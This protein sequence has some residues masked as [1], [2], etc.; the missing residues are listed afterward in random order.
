VLAHP[1]VIEAARYEIE[2]FDPNRRPQT[3]AEW[4]LVRRG[5][6]EWLNNGLELLA[7]M[8][9]LSTG[10]ID[11]HLTV[12]F[13]RSNLEL[14]AI[15]VGDG[16]LKHFEHVARSIIQS[17]RLLNRDDLKATVRQTRSVAGGLNRTNTARL[18]AALQGLPAELEYL[19]KPILAIA[20]QDQDLLGSGE[21]DIRPLERS[22]RKVAKPGAIAGTATAHAEILHR[23]L[24]A[25][26]ASDE[27][28]AASLWFVEGCL[29]GFARF[30]ADGFAP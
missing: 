16:E 8:R 18:S 17:I 28:W 3:G 1:D 19:R 25:L 4:I 23:W 10:N 26:P 14:A 11:H 30:G 29:R 7:D 15:I 27:A 5:K 20:K 9:F 24:T 22:L 2:A 6:P 21:G 12:D 13:Q